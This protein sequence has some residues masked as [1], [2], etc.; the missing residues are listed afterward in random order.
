[1]AGIAAALDERAR[2]GHELDVGV[3]QR[4]QAF[5]VALPDRFEGELD[6][7]N[8]LLRHGRAAVFHSG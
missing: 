5:D 1:V 3:V 2:E 6:D 8:V 4:E 7:F